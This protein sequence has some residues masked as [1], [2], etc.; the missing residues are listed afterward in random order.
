MLWKILA[1]NGR[2]LGYPYFSWMVDVM[3]KSWLEMD[4]N[5]G[6]GPILGNL[7]MI[8]WD[9]YVIVSFLGIKTRNGQQSIENNC[10][11]YR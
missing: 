11:T 8:G 4:E 1:R 7:N 9:L 3:E 6:F 2:E 5:Q 10:F